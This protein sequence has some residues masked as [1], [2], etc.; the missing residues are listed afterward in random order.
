MPSWDFVT[1]GVMQ[2][3]IFIS[4]RREDS[5][6]EAG[7]LR[8]TLAG[9]F[10]DEAV[11]MDTSSIQAGS[12]WPS[13]IRSSLDSAKAVLVVMGRDWLRISDEW[14]QRRIDQDDDPVGNELVQALSRDKEVIP[15]LVNGSRV[16]PRDKL[17]PSISD[18]VDRQVI[19]IRTSYWDHDVKLLLSKLESL[20]ETPPAQEPV[21]PYPAGPYPVPP[22]ELPDPISEENLAIALKGTLSHWSKVSSPLPE[23]PGRVRSEL[24]REYRFRSFRDAIRFMSEVA[25]G[26]D[27]AIHHPRWE[28][29][30]K[31]LRVYLTTWDIGHRISDRDVQLAKYFDIAYSNFA[32]DNPKDL[33]RP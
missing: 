33:A 11:F 10:G 2:P 29:I 26:C 27:I 19:E 5:A 20:A 6:A 12:K 22:P 9:Q 17:P 25:P 32:R 15:I 30:W 23:N 14:G 21:G 4:Y 18:L 28:N 8:A 3:S 7:R 1:G 24:F 31:T 13:E 16:P